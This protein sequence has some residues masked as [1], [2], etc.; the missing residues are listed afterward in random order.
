MFPYTFVFAILSRR[1]RRK[2]LDRLTHEELV[3]EYNSG[4]IEAFE[5]IIDHFERPLFFYA[6][7]RVQ[8]EEVARDIVQETFLKFVQHAHRYD[9]SSPL[10]AWLYTI[11]RNKC[12]DYLRKRRHREVSMDQSLKDGE[13]VNLHQFLEDQHPDSS[14][15]VAAKEIAGR[16]DAALQEINPDQREIFL[17]RE[18]HGLKFIEIAE[19]LSISE[20]TVKS[21]MRYALEALRRHL[22][23]FVPTL[24][25]HLQ[26]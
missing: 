3:A 21:R 5:L 13:D 22:D 20:N 7:R 11:T 26:P 2:P 17:L 6:L 25:D 24:P 4:R 19:I 8:I 23:D 14:D 9:P 1:R 15:Q 16:I 12:I 10:S 18:V